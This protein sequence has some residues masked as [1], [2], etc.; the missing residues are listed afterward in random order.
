MSGYLQ[1]IVK[2]ITIGMGIGIAIMLGLGV[3]SEINIDSLNARI[4][5]N[6]GKRENIQQYLY[7]SLLQR[8]C[9]KPVETPTDIPTLVVLRNQVNDC[10]DL[11][12]VIKIAAAENLKGLTEINN[13]LVADCQ[14]YVNK[15]DTGIFSQLKPSR[16]KYCNRIL[17][18]Y[19]V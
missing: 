15:W 2:K 7:S 11:D 4:E 13:Q 17:A 19:G 3:L 6:T 5:R 10:K 12:N 16:I 1:S 8:N 9:T 18:E 14:T